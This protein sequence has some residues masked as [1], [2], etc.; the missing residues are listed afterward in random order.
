MR[1]SNLTVIVTIVFAVTKF[2][3]DAGAV[4]VLIPTLVFIFFL[5]HYHYRN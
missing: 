5:I 1:Q 3:D 4:V 2:E